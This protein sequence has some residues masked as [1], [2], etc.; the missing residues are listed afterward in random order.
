MKKLVICFGSNSSDGDRLIDV[1]LGKV[2]S[3]VRWPIVSTCYQSESYPAE[4]ASSALY[5]NRVLLGWTDLSLS[6]LESEFKK[7]EISMGRDQNARDTGLVPIDI[8]I[9]IVDDKIIRPKDYGRPYFITGYDEI[10][11]SM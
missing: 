3:F 4:S 5:F 2:L 10:N 9:I 11:S 6:V 8:D 1:A 7:I